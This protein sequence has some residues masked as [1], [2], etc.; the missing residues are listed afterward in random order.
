[1]AEK[2]HGRNKLLY[3]PNTLFYTFTMESKLAMPVPE[4]PSET[5]VLKESPTHLPYPV[6]GNKWGG[7]AIPVPELSFKRKPFGTVKRIEQYPLEGKQPPEGYIPI[8]EFQFCSVS[9]NT[10][11]MY[12]PYASGARSKDST[13]IPIPGPRFNAS[14]LDPPS[15]PPP[16]SSMLDD[17]FEQCSGFKRQDALRQ[18]ALHQVKLKAGQHTPVNGEMGRNSLPTGERLSMLGAELGAHPRDWCI[19]EA[20]DGVLEAVSI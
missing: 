9:H 6:E 20:G 13:T 1:M 3:F 2:T 7:L 14:P 17:V 8:P 10:S 11:S 15:M 16:Y 19:P 4:L 12:L 5:S 18:N